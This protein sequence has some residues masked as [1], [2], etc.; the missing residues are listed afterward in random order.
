MATTDVV[1]TNGHG[2]ALQTG[3]LSSDQVGLIKRQILKPK[4]RDATDDELALFLAQCERTGLDPF[5]RQIYGIYRKQSGAEMLS[6]Q[7]SI[8]GFRLTAERSGK[9]IG[10]DG[11]FWCGPDG[12]WSDIWVGQERPIAAKVI[13]RKVIGGQVAETPAVAHFG[14]YVPM[15]DGK[16]TGQWATMPALMIAKCAEALALRKAFPQE[17][18]GLYTSEEME[19]ADL[20]VPVTVSREDAVVP[21]IEPPAPQL[22]KTV[23]DELVAAKNAINMP[24]EWVRQRLIAVGVANVPSGKPSLKT[25]KALTE[26]QASN[27]LEF[28]T[29][30]AEKQD[31]AALANE[32]GEP[33]DA[34][35]VTA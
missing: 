2:M 18:S 7:T 24:D 11:P 4:N 28:F 32:N 17:L 8:D 6:I 34:N 3:G 29:I 10:Q 31:A 15:Y 26:Q 21:Q 19:Q 27:L 13:V 1:K 23:V 20:A 16:P 25:I 9:Y 33:V 35:G 30:E 22:P 12:K 5:A 14:E